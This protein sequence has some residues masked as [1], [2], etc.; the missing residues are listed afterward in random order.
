MYVYRSIW[1]YVIYYAC[2]NID[3][4]FLGFVYDDMY[5]CV[6]TTMPIRKAA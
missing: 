4:I 5:M 3:F 6:H 2:Y 1:Y